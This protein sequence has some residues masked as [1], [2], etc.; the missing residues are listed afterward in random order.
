ML[1]APITVTKTSHYNNCGLV[2]TRIIKLRYTYYVFFF[3]V[4]ALQGYE[5]KSVIIS[6][7]LFYLYVSF[8]FIQN[9]QRRSVHRMVQLVWELVI[10]YNLVLLVYQFVLCHIQSFIGIKIFNFKLEQILFKSKHQF[11]F[12]FFNMAFSYYQFY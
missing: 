1:I 6:E 5:S 3:C 9:S 7:L 4:I 10:S 8:I 11:F 2:Q 12:F